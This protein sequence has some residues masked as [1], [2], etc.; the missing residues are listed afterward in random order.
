MAK[1]QVMNEEVSTL[2]EVAAVLGV[3]KV[4][5]AEV[6]NG[7]YPE[8]VLINEEP[9]E[10]IILGED[11][12]PAEPTLQEIVEESD[13][14]EI[15]HVTDTP[16]DEVEDSQEEDTLPDDADTIEEIEYP[17]VGDFKDVK[18]MKRYI[19]K[20][21]DEELQA[22]CELEGVEWKPNDHVSINRMRMAMAIKALHFPETKSSGKAKKKSKYAQ[23]E[24]E[25]LI[26]MALDNDIE[27]PDAKGDPRIERMYVIMALRKEGLIS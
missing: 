6:E 12:T 22:W 7:K 16:T 17:E 3:S 20:L 24:T 19:K 13:N 1:Y 9:T 14:I 18:A 10:E 21:S 11:F 25:E 23:Y 27:V 8:V 5:K 15:I 4:T 26:Q 2:K